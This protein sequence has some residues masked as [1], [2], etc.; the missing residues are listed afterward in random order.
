[1]KHSHFLLCL[2]VLMFLDG[3]PLR[4]GDITEKNLRFVEYPDFADAHSTWGSIGYSSKHNK[5]F[6]GVTNH[7]NRQ[8]LYEYDV[9]SKTMRLRG[10]IDEL[11]HLR[12]FQW[13]GKIH[14]Q[15]VEG[16]GGAMYFGTDGGESREEY[17]MNHPQ[18]YG[19]GF[20]M[21]WDPA[22]NRLTNLG[23]T[24]Q[25]ESIKDVAVDQVNGQIYAVSYPQ[26]HLLVYDYHQNSL[27]DLGRMG[28]DHVPRVM[29]RDGWSNFYY[30]DW[31]QRLI[32]YER[33]TGKLIFARESLP[34]FKGTPGL[35]I[36]TGITSYAVDKS[37]GVI[38]LITYGSKMLAF[39]PQKSG[40]GPVEDLGGIYDDP[41]RPPYGYYCPNL[42]LGAN[43]KLYYF[44]GGHGMYA[45]EKPSV[46]L[47]EFDP[48]TRVKHAVLRFPLEVINEVTGSDVKDKD[49]NL[50]FAG[51]RYSRRAQR[52][53]ESGASR[54]FMIIFN[55]EKELQ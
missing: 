35:S 17:L 48:A 27:R 44:L 30:V 54:P 32:K 41:K 9:P 39:H 12:D 28:S 25:Y 14:T 5:V 46:A 34:W 15:I 53:G 50:Y 18:G 23:M 47:M 31:R 21:R 36:I 1:M 2:M 16:P 3:Y 20:L 19:G 6:I 43:G 13:Q 8:G 40:I 10:F 26:V 29:F 22:T 38:Y 51:R 11:A 45:G 33:D 4:A 49:G 52:M 37:S 55:P 42:A 7:R 24:L